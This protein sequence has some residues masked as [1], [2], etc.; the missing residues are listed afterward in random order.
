MGVRTIGSARFQVRFDTVML[1]QIAN[2]NCHPNSTF[3]LR[4]ELGDDDLEAGGDF[5]DLGLDLSLLFFEVMGVTVTVGRDPTEDSTL[6]DGPLL[7]L[8]SLPEKGLWRIPTYL[9]R[10]WRNSCCRLYDSL[11]LNESHSCWMTTIHWS[12]VIVAGVYTTVLVSMVKSSNDDENSYNKARIVAVRISKY[13]TSLC[14][15]ML[16]C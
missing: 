7:L 13:P 4:E 11:S 3:L 16:F 5:C 14:W 10:Q 2:T 9:E 15:P 6:V 1:C 12:F 8:K